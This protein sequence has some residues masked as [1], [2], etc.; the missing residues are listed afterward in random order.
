MLL[1][2]AAGVTASWATTRRRLIWKMI[3]A[4]TEIAPGMANAMKFSFIGSSA[5][6][7]QSTQQWTYDGPNATAPRRPP[8]PG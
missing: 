4:K 6:K 2:H 7:K 5:A 1:D 8:Q 3:M